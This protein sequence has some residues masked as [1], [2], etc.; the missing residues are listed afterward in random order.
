MSLWNRCRILD[1]LQHLQS[2]LF[3]PG[4]SLW[5]GELVGE[6][7]IK[8]GVEEVEDVYKFLGRHLNKPTGSQA[9]IG[10]AIVSQE[11]KDLPV[12]D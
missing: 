10:V 6:G 7:W 5:H 8:E 1:H 11:I 3:E 4:S 9:C 2:L 12:I